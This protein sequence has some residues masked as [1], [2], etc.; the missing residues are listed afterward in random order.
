MTTSV[1]R[2]YII[3]DD[4]RSWAALAF[5]LSMADCLKTVVTAMAAPHIPNQLT[6]VAL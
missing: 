5:I 3:A 1:I 6:K 2:P 4:V